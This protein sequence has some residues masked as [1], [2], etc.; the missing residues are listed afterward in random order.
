MLL[1]KQTIHIYPFIYPKNPIGVLWV[2]IA[3]HMSGLMIIIYWTHKQI[4]QKQIAEIAEIAFI[5][6]LLQFQL[7]SAWSAKLK[8]KPIS[9]CQH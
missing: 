3:E 6:C 1:Q 8:R 7:C 9:L 2:A 5:G 4:C